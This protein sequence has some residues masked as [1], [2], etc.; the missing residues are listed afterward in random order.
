MR[1]QDC[2]IEKTDSSI[3]AKNIQQLSTVVA[4]PVHRTAKRKRR[5][6][7]PNPK[8]KA[9]KSLEPALQ[10]RRSL[11]PLLQ[12]TPNNAPT[13]LSSRGHF[14]SCPY[15]E[16]DLI[17]LSEPHARI[18]A[19]TASQVETLLPNLDLSPSA[20]CDKNYSALFEYD[21][22]TPRPL[23]MRYL[24][25][26]ENFSHAIPNYKFLLTSQERID[27]KIHLRAFNYQLLSVKEFADRLHPSQPPSMRIMQKRLAEGGEQFGL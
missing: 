5:R 11:T 2:A 1:P 23:K 26:V 9:R 13:Y 4:T 25:V 16:R 18:R 8:K 10:A 12:P 21:Q 3:R 17:Q 22:K 20:L 15:R 7:S 19:I 14:V 24:F 6:L 27:L